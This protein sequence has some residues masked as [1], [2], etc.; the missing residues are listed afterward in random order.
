M[1]RVFVMVV[2]FSCFT[3]PTVGQDP[4]TIYYEIIE[5]DSVMLFFNARHNFVER[6][7]AE[8]TRYTRIDADGNFNGYFED[9]NNENQ[10]LGRGSYDHG[11]KH[12][13]F[14][15][16]YPSGKLMSK[17]GY[18]GD[19]PVGE[20]EYFYENGLPE[21]TLRFA[22]DEVLVV[23]FIDK[24]GTPRVSNGIGEFEGIVSGNTGS[25]AILAEGR[26]EDGK[27]VGKWT[28]T[29]YNAIYC[30]EEYS[31]GK[32]IRGVFPN[33]K[34]K[35]S[36]PYTDKSF[37]NTFLLVNYLHSLEDF[38]LEKCSIEKTPINKYTFDIQKFNAFAHSRI[39]QVIEHDFR[40]G[41][42][43]D[44]LVGDNALIIKFSV[45]KEGKP[46]DF[47]LLTGWGQQFFNA[48]TNSIST[49]AKFR[50]GET[51]FFHLKLHFTSDF[52]YKYNFT[53]SRDRQS[54]LN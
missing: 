42:S 36:K 7:C 46:D 16:Y 17:G 24:A 34:G 6:K 9:V 54:P 18:I 48:I 10:I 27:P 38:H 37:L 11:V 45:D 8:Y 3:K 41:N 31:N 2:F 28:S 1:T 44:Y 29:Y 19:T 22:G 15:I 49:Q 40:S 5:G 52:M 30:K 39:D 50:P 32:I 23:R 26:I 33:A 51:L 12:G 20:W 43:N 4:S 14:E 53:F 47:F 25:N 13:Y 21:R 35:G